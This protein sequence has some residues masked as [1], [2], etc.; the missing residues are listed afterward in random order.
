M[1]TKLETAV[2]A[3]D[4]AIGSHFGRLPELRPPDLRDLV[5]ICGKGSFDLPELAAIFT[6]E[7]KAMEEAQ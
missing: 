5:T 7:L 2:A 3:L 1:N 4:A 6:A